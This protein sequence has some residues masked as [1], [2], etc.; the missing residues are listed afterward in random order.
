MQVFPL[1]G[2]GCGKPMGIIAFVTEVGSIQRILESSARGP[3]H[4]E[5]D[6]DP[7]KG[8]NPALNDPCPSMSSLNG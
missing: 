4:W 8:T 2:T 5:E 3:P 6:F 1:L 7:R